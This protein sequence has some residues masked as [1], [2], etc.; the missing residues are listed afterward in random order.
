ME[1][2]E[3]QIGGFDLIY[4][5]GPVQL[6]AESVYRT[7]LGCYAPRNEN[8]KQLAKGAAQRL[9]QSESRPSRE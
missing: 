1:G 4:K 5:G 8:L 7:F 3:T 6:P 2:N 9:A